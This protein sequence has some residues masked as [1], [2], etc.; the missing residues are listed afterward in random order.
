[1]L[2]AC[3]SCHDWIGAHPAAAKVERVGWALEEWQQPTECPV[4]YRGRLVYLDDIGAVHDFEEA[5]T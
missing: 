1:V 3:R 5:C 4:L 2:W